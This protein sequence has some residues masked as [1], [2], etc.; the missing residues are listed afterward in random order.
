MAKIDFSKIA[1]VLRSNQQSEEKITEYKAFYKKY[2][3]SIKNTK[4]ILTKLYPL[5][6]KFQKFK[7]LTPLYA[8]PA[9]LALEEEAVELL[10]KNFKPEVLQL[11][12]KEISSKAS[13]KQ[14]GI[15]GLSWASFFSDLSTVLKSVNEK[16]QEEWN[17]KTNFLIFLNNCLADFGLYAGIVRRDIKT[18][19]RYNFVLEHDFKSKVKTTEYKILLSAGE[20][21][22]EFLR[23]YEKKL[24]IKIN[25]KL[26]PF[27][28]F[29][30]VQ[31]TTSMLLDDEIELYGKKNNFVWNNTEKE[32]LKF[33][34]FCLDETDS[35]LKNPFLVNENDDLRNQNS[36]FVDPLRIAELKSLKGINFD[37][38]RLIQLCEELNSN[39]SSK[40]VYS[41]SFLLR[42]VIDHIPPIFNF[43]NFSEFANKYPDGTQSFKKSMLHLDKSLRN[44]A[45]NNI[46]SQVRNKEVIP[47]FTQIDFRQDLD[48]LL[49]EVVRILK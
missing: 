9:K 5:C 22:R 3:M 30:R 43:P 24:S 32:K 29:C 42:S 19:K 7:P 13:N 4:E 14:T 23:P 26:I 6:V 36:H 10:S 20:L 15:D 48:V 41:L 18:Y 34:S 37:L 38:A 17:Y 12:K 27:K 47:T 25:G 1:N 28:N 2:L 45:D 21:Q 11:Y 35:L 31:I 46:H 44:I 39:S 16:Y 40:N 33:I 8:D 49:S